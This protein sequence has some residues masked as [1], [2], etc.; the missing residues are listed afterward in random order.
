MK[1]MIRVRVLPFAIASL[2]AMAPV[3]AQNITTSGA[4]G[5]VL[6]AHGQP[7]AGAIVTIVHEPSG[8]TKTVTTDADGR[9]AAQGLRVGGPFAITASKGGLAGAEQDNVYLQ[10]GQPSSINLTMGA[11]AAEASTLGAVT[12]SASTLAQ[13]FST[14]NKGLSTNISQRQLQATPQGNRSID[15]VARLD[16][17]ITVTDQ[18]TGAISAAGMNNRFNNIAVDGVTQG[19]PFGLNANGLPYQ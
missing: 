9:Y 1:S 11:A 2:L 13:T 15:D 14:E 6:D 10:L 16:P 18:G 19:D 7:V 17:R 5:R 3:A 8:T 12:V 4:N